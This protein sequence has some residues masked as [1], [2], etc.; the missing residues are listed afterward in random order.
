MVMFLPPN[1]NGRRRHKSRGLTSGVGI[2]TYFAF[3]FRSNETAPKNKKLTDDQIAS[4]VEKEFSH[5]PSAFYFRGPNKRRTINE[6]RIKYNSGAFTD[7]KMP[8]TH[9]YRYDSLG[10]RVNGRTGKPLPTIQELGLQS[11]HKYWSN[12]AI[13]KDLKRAE[14]DQ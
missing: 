10:N 8:A 9:S 12:D 13:R 7:G 3:L 4:L 11:A 2:C 5:R 14:E 1:N 6:Y